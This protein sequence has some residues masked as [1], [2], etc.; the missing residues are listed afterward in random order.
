MCC[1]RAV[2]LCTYGRGRL[3]AVGETPLAV[4]RESVATYISESEGL[5]VSRTKDS[6]YL[7]IV[8]WEGPLG[9]FTYLADKRGV[10]YGL[11]EGDILKA[12]IVGNVITV[13][14]N[15]V[16][17]AQ[18]KDDTYQTGNPGIGT[19]LSCDGGRGVGSNRDF[20]FR[21]FTARGID[22]NR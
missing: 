7:Q 15:G 17:K 12:S 10:N 20:G 22:A 8:R 14:I 6:S 4:R 19:F 16:E 11:K 2:A 13:F 9:K 18:V 21:N 1:G 3:Q 5:P